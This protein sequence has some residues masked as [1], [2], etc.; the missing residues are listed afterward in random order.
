MLS[1]IQSRKGSHSP[2]AF[3]STMK[4]AFIQIAQILRRAT[5]ENITSSLTPVSEPRVVQAPPIAMP[6]T[7][8]AELRVVPTPAPTKPVFTAPPP[9]KAI[10]KPQPVS[11][12][13]NRGTRPMP[14]QARLPTRHSAQN[15]PRPARSS[16]QAVFR[17]KYA[18][19]I[20]ALA[21]TPI[22]GKQASLTKLLRGPDSATWLRSNANKWG[23]LLECGIGKDRPLSERITGSGTIFFIL[24]PSDRHV[25]YANYAV[26]NIRPQKTETHRVHMTAGGDQLD[27]PGDASS[28]AVA[29]LDAKLHINSTISDAHK[30]ARYLGIDIK[31]YYL[32]TPLKYYQYIHV[33]AKRIPQEVWD[34]PRYAPHIEPDGFVNLEICRGMYG[35]KEAGILAFEQL[36]VKLAPH[37]YE[38]APYTPGLWRHI[39]KPT[40]FTLCENDFG[41]K[42]F[43]KADALHLVTALHKD[44]E[45]TTS[46]AGLLYCGLTLDWH[47]DAGYV[48]IP[49]PGYVNQTLSKFQHPTPKRSQHAPH[50][51]IEPVYGSKQQQKPT[52]AAGAAPLDYTGTKRVQS[53]KKSLYVLQ[54]SRQPLH[55]CRPQRDLHRIGKT[56]DR[57]TR[58]NRHANGLP[59]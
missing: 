38:P 24:I 56:D 43:T 59:T 41:V 10:K 14:G 3:G 18:H 32:G 22:A 35:L 34:D 12:P 23:R 52:E 11:R 8:V 53:E 31:N 6:I 47:Y 54:P 37:G 40:T 49:M 21:T 26:C 33:L 1:I 39:T 2:L 36:V 16:A 20:A 19:H 57:H 58:E 17:H 50:Q 51:W 46:W 45:I 27:Y 48:D 9:I 42:Y 7:P 13:A 55:S 30:G 29:M 4:K 5:K 25:L 15:A 28:P 44:Y